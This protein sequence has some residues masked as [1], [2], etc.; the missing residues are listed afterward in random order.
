MTQRKKTWPKKED[1]I[2]RRSEEEMTKMKKKKKK[3]KKKKNGRFKSHFFKCFF[4]CGLS[5]SSAYGGRPP[6]F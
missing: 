1:E 5:K 3:R 2:T 4:S 6:P